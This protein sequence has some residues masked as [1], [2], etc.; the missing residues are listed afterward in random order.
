MITSIRT[1]FA[2][3]TKVPYGLDLAEVGQIY[4]ARCKVIAGLFLGCFFL[5]GLYML[6]SSLVGLV[7]ILA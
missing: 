6:L 2:T 3:A 4:L 1:T 7:A 5:G